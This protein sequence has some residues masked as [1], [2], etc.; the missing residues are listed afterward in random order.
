[1]QRISLIDEL[2]RGNQ[3]LTKKIE[4]LEDRDRMHR[5]TIAQLKYSLESATNEN[6][7]LRAQLCPQRRSCNQLKGMLGAFMPFYTG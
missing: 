1:M 7:A 3:T 2:K 5:D 6:A 4:A